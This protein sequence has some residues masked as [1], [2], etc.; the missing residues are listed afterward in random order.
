MGTMGGI[1][2]EQAM[3]QALLTKKGYDPDRADQ[4]EKQRIYGFLMRRGFSG[5]QVRRAI[6]SGDIYD[7]E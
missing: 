3:I 6:F 7:W 2:N 5:E 1:R 4:K